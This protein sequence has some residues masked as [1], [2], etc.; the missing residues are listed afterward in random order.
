MSRVRRSCTFCS[1]PTDP[2]FFVIASSLPVGA[3]TVH[4]ILPTLT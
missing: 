2:R 1:N 4:S 3:G